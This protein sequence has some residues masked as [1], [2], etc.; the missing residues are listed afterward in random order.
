MI[1][2]L[3]RSF[4]ALF[5]VLGVTFLYTLCLFLAVVIIGSLVSLIMY[6]LSY[7]NLNYVATICIGFFALLFILCFLIFGINEIINIKNGY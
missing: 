6:I 3:Y 1:E 7:F 2:K 5:K 4:K